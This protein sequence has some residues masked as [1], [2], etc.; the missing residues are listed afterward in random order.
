MLG[1]QTL[2][3]DPGR[4]VCHSDGIGRVGRQDVG[5]V[6][7]NRKTRELV[8]A[9]GMIQKGLSTRTGPICRTVKDAARI[10][11]AFA[12]YD[13]AD[14]LTAFSRGRLPETPYYDL[15]TAGLHG[16]AARQPL[17]G[18]RIGV[19]REYM[20][21]DL[22]PIYD[23]ETIDLVDDAIEVL[24]ELGATI[25]DP[26]PHGALFQACV[27]KNVPVWN[28]QQFMRSFPSEFPFD[29]DGEPLDDHISKLV[30]MFLDPSL[31]PHTATGRPS[32]RN[33]GGSGFD[34]GDTRYNFEVYIRERGD[35]EI[36]SL[37]DLYEKADFWESQPNVGNRA[38]SLMSADEE[39]TLATASSTQDRHTVQTVVYDCFASMDLDA[40]VYPSSNIAPGVAT[41]PE[42][43]SVND[44]GTNWTTISVHG[45]P[46]LTVPAGFTTVVYDRS[47]EDGSIITPTPAAMPVG[48]DILALPF[49]DKVVFAIGHAY[50]AATH[51]R[52]PPPA[53]GPVE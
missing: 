1:P 9:D 13:P 20:D 44:R 38:G 2:H 31:V 12:G 29:S 47:P 34:T 26:G 15:P 25:V 48:L 11:D 53:F 21:K 28:N 30:E 14:E 4:D 18:Y 43:P 50:E 7:A 16:K 8:S 41:S 49:D 22:F 5:V 52:T 37:T 3:E 24:A 46:A 19:I 51:H 10:L 32:I 39:L 6:I 35:A 42:L 23:H 40:V 17:D 45:F 33:I 27:D 36:Q